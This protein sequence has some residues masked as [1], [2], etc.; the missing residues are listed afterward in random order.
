MVGHQLAPERERILPGRMRQLVD[1]ALEIDRVLVE[2]HAAPEA[3]R[4]GRVAHRMVDQ[5]RRK[6]VADRGF[7]SRRVEALEH[8]RILAV[9]DVRRKEPGD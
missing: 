1:E 6:R 8:N 4:N 7:R 2:I 5:Q 3:G 9:L